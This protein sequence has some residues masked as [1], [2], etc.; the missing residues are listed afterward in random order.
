MTIRQNFYFDFFQFLKTKFVRSEKNLP[1]RSL[2]RTV[3]FVIER[4]TSNCV[5]DFRMNLIP[6]IIRDSNNFVK[7]HLTELSGIA[8]DEGK[9]WKT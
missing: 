6:N 1:D 7:T 8:N 3:E 4:V 5:K 2:Q 9:S